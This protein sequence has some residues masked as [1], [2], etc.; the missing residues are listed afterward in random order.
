M[1]VEDTA[2]YI[3]EVAGEVTLKI[4]Q[5]ENS[6]T[7]KS[8]AIAGE[9]N[10][11]DI[12][13]ILFNDKIVAF[14]TDQLF[15][16]LNAVIDERQISF[17]VYSIKLMKHDDNSLT[18]RVYSRDHSKCKN[19]REY[20]RFSLGTNG[21]VQLGMHHSTR[22]CIIR[23]ISYGGFGLVIKEKVHVSLN[24][25]MNLHFDH[26]HDRSKITVSVNAVV[27]RS[28]YNSEED[29]TVIGLKLLRDNSQVHQVVNLIQ[30]DELFK[31]KHKK[32][33]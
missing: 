5:G 7:L 14:N 12:E 17:R 15:I 18:H 24:E 11:L 2:H 30:Q 31:L 10:W 25:L 32:E 4:T 29:E 8:R 26:T 27:V 19:L 20:K 6:I 23:D 3:S 1:K 21:I 33:E 13:P 28:D 22:E 16:N 9:G